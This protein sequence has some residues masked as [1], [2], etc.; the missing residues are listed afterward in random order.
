MLFRSDR[1]AGSLTSNDCYEVIVMATKD[2]QT[3]D[4]YKE[5]IANCEAAR[6]ASVEASID[7]AQIK[8]AMELVRTIEKKS[9]K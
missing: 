8:K 2:T 6:Y 3:A 4:R 1:T 7:S 9:K 5:I